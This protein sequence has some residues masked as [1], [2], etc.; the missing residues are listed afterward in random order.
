MA[1]F[2]FKAL[3][4][5][6]KEIKGRMDASSEDVVA[7][8][9]RDMGY[10]PTE[11][12][13]ERLKG[14]AQQDVFDLP[15]VRDI[16]KIL[17]RGKVKHKH[18]ANF[19]RQMATLIGAGLP[20]VRSLRVL[21]EQSESRNLK[22]ALNM[23]AD[24]IEGGSTFSE[25]LAKH[26]RI[27]NRLFINMVKAGEVG[28]ALEQVLDRLAIFAEKA[29]A[30]R[31]K[32]KGALWYPSAVILIACG[33][34]YVILRYV[35]PPFEELYEG[36]GAQLPTLTQM[37][38]RFS[39]KLSVYTPIAIGTVFVTTVLYKWSTNKF[40][41]VRFIADSVK[42]KLPLFGTLIQK[43][44]IARF[45][46]TFGTLLDT[47]VP[48]LQSL[49]IVKDTVG[50]EVVSRAMVKVHASIR[51]GETISEPLRNFS[52][53]PPL[54]IHMIAVGEE[55]GAIDAMLMKVA[56]AYEREVD[57]AVEGIM[58][59]IEPVLIVI[60]G[61]IIGFIVVALYLPIFNIINLIGS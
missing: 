9:L 26:P 54:V 42:L 52:V 30:I 1:T 51:D 27:F 28:G 25:A 39:K 7:E 47:G 11:V 10:F 22:D 48:I 35:V 17:T 12:S 61:F 58:S 14:A 20:L 24:D 45:A 3:D 50:N 8:K 13:R 2:V 43:A 34:V 49:M 44:S 59:L 46:R 36:M 32:V 60:L 38:I 53:F 57:D 23:V 31:S 21:V 5:A 56:D 19:T 16:V 4:R 40:E 41:F 18:L 33:V 15:V 29:M 6:G 55:T 37:L